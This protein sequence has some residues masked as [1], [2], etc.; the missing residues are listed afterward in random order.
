[1]R[2]FEAGRFFS[3]TVLLLA[4]SVMSLAS[5]AHAKTPRPAVVRVAAPE[6]GG[7]AYGSGTLVGVTD[8]HGLVLTNWHVVRDATGTI[9][10][11]FPD[12]YRSAATVL[13]TDETWDLAA[14]LIWR[15]KNI[16]PVSI[17]SAEP[18]SGEFMTIAGY[19][20]GEYREA[21]GKVT[22]FV[23]PQGDHPFEI[24]E[25][26]TEARQGDS[27]GPIINR[28]GQ[29]AGVLFG[30]ANG[31]TAGSHCSRVRWFVRRALGTM[32]RL[33]LAVLPNTAR[34]TST[35]RAQSPRQ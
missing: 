9:S 19:G 32:P 29:L 13:K 6:K 27:G 11:E 34:N 15:P 30:S 35:V 25:V 3:V 2:A 31:R 28:R 22:Q 18:N 4:I 23:A 14:L 17:A 16:E 1:M 26:G 21:S 8:K 33:A 7:T 12:G 10:V 24:V 5:A 20:S